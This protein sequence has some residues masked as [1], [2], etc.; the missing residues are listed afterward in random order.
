MLAALNTYAD[1]IAA[2]EICLPKTGALGSLVSYATDPNTK[3][4]QPMHVNF[5]L[6]PPLDEE[7]KKKDE[8]RRRMTQRAQR[9]FDAY[10][11][12]RHDIFVQEGDALATNL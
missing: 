12:T 9:D 8:R 6:F 10:L 4:Y 3:E 2:P 7:I 11:S 5:G 1:L